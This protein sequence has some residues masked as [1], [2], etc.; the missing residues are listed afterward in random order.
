[1]KVLY[2][3]K[4]LR[5]AAYRSKLR[6]LSEHVDLHAVMPNRW[7]LQEPEPDGAFP[8]ERRRTFLHGH[9]HLHL[10][11]QPDEPVHEF[12]PDLV[13]IDEEPYSAVTAQYVRVCRRRR[14]PCLFFAWQ[15]IDKRLPVPFGALRRFVFHRAHG[16]IAGTA[17]AAE[18]LHAAGWRGPLA[19]IPQ[20]GVDPERFRPDEE[21]RAA[22]RARIGARETDWV[23]GFGG[24][25]VREKGLFVLLEAV[26][27]QDRVRTVVIGDG[28]MR[29]TFCAR[30]VQPDLKNR[31]SHLGEVAS[32][33]MPG[34]LAGLDILV[35]PSLSTASWK[36]Q[37]GRILVEAMACGVP[38]I[39][40]D[41]GEIPNVIGDAGVIVP[42]N[43]AAALRDA[44]LALCRD[45]ARRRELGECGRARVLAKFTG[46]RIAIET[47]AFYEEVLACVR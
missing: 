1:M 7:S 41:S 32:L 43:D 15:N 37:F 36:E 19:V 30:A 40:S 26:A 25:L 28:P 17:A 31:T 42:E 3:S 23:V 18:V 11:R 5:V 4:A 20:F 38:V 10:Y 14:L 16:A 9:N 8:V 44:I 35:L 46:K 13:H 33:D 34:T 27:G 12:R 2:V 47:A 21:A 22:L 6:D 45:D 29:E 24:R 39:G